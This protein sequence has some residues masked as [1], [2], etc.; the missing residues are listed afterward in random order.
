MTTTEIE[1]RQLEA[2]DELV[3][4]TEAGTVIKIT[5]SY[6]GL[7]QRYTSDPDSYDGVDWEG[8]SANGTPR[9]GLLYASEKVQVASR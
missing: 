3:R 6:V 4:T 1:A 9:R 8:I 2:G 7:C 5:M